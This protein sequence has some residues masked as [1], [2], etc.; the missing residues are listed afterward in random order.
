[1]TNVYSEISDTVDN[2]VFDKAESCL[3]QEVRAVTGRGTTSPIHGASH[4]GLGNLVE[5]AVRDLVWAP[6]YLARR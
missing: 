6:M 4:A 2:A 3:N 5:R 1:V